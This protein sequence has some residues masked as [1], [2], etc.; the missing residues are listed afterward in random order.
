[1][2]KNCLTNCRRFGVCRIVER[3]ITEFNPVKSERDKIYERL[4]LTCEEYEGVQ[5]KRTLP[6]IQGPAPCPQYERGDLP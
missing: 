2:T 4:A 6:A 3:E 1:M 5:S